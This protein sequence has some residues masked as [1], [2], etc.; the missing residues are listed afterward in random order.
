MSSDLDPFRWKYASGERIIDIFERE[1]ESSG[2]IRGKGFW[3]NTKGTRRFALIKGRET[4]E[5]TSVGERKFSQKPGFLFHFFSACQIARSNS[6][7]NYYILDKH[8]HITMNKIS[9]HWK[10]FVC[11]Y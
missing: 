9:L 2:F 11:T 7:S 1:E 8:L 3:R 6:L 10:P 4:I 5:I